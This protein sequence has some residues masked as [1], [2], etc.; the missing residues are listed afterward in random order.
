MNRVVVLKGMFTP[1]DLEKEPGLA[2]ELKEDVEEEA[3]TLGAVTSVTLYDVSSASCPFLSTDTSQKEE[4]GVMTIRFKDSAA[5]DACV[6]KMNGR[7]FD[8]RQVSRTS[9]SV[10]VQIAEC[11]SG[12]ST[13]EYTQAGSGIGSQTLGSKIRIRKNLRGW[14]SL[15]NGWWTGMRVIVDVHATLGLSLEPPRTGQHASLQIHKSTVIRT[16]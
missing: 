3:E 15:L 16:V 14:T 2:Q 9:L 8:G 13:L 5:A 10:L 11:S 6:K 4:D 12:R 7:F 1:E